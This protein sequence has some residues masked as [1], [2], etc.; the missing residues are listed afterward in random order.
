MNELH[1]MSIRKFNPGTFLSDEEVIEQFVVRKHELDIALEILR[2]NIDSPSCQH[3]LVVAPRGLGK[4]MLLARIAAELNTD[5][6]LSKCL[7]PVRFMEESHEIFNI[8]DFWLETLFHLARESV[9]YDSMLARELRVTYADLADRWLEKELANR[10]RAAVLD[11]ADRL[12]KKLVLMVENLQTLYED[13]DEDFGWQLRGALQTEP[14]IMLLATATS[15]F[16]GLDDAEQPFFEQFRILDLEPLN[17][18]ECRR[19][20]QVV[21]GD[22]VGDREIRPLEILTGGNPRL[23]VII[24]EFAQHRSLSQLM[25][26]L[27]TLIDDHTEY[28]RGHLEVLPKNERRVYLSVIDLWQP[29]SAGEIA[30]RARMDVRYVSTM[31]GRLVNRGAVTFK[32]TGRKRQYE[33]VERLYSI[34]YKLRRERDD[35]ALVENLINFMVAFYSIG[36]LY[37]MS[38]KLIA[39][40]AESKVIREGIQRALAR[41]PPVEDF[42]SRIAWSAI[43]DVSDSATAN[44][45]TTAELRLEE[46]INAAIQDKEFRS[47]IE[48]ADRFIASGGVD[49]SRS[50]ELL[51]AYILNMKAF[52]YEQLTDFQAVIAVCNEVVK[53]FGDTRDFLLRRRVAAALVYTASARRGLGDFEMA[54]AI[55]D[56]VIEYFSNYDK[57]PFREEEL[58]VAA[59]VDKGIAQEKLRDFEAA[60]A[61]Y[62]EVVKRFGD[63]D[64]L[65]IQE[66]VATALNN[67]GFAQRRLGD[68]EAAIETYEEVLERF[69]SSGVLEIR[70]LVAMVLMNKGFA[71]QKLNDAEGEI[72][73]YNE[74]IK[75][76]SD[77]QVQVAIALSYKGMKEAEMGRAAEAL[78]TCEELERRLNALPEDGN[79]WFEWQVMC[80]KALALM[81]QKKRQTAMDAFRSAYAAFPPNN[82]VTLHE[83]QR[84]VPGLI[85]NGAS[86]RDLIEILSS[87]KEK[88]DALVPLIVALLQRAGEV[89]RAPVEVLEVAKD[90]N[91]DIER[92]MSD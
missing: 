64:A 53:R 34:Y 44:A 51:I 17:T 50:P 92:R 75:H 89:V 42:S 67:K 39:E 37:Q 91:K 84:I 10:V 55:C 6:E 19:L 52:A 7:L 9:R 77:H 28:F 8:A 25:E 66:R 11:A 18:E 59:L 43:K 31:L 63:S 71:L 81:V 5:T 16:K 24:A 23:L 83:M 15:R 12:G 41:R 57:Q 86:E 87:D 65:E 48:I 69:G 62:D 76:F 61:S 45:Q 36:E 40:A 58:V 32:G 13:V 46:E 38:G 56:E 78:Q 26:E 2:G 27:V 88:L 49:S 21:S 79:T 29:S 68:F 3:V 73:A 90:I 22:E 14:Q 54:I 70:K 33:A 72:A 85:A 4:T 30:V 47:V 74:V 1:N 82:E 20:W 35:R 60:I 80:V